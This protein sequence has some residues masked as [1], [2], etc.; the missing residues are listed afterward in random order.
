MSKY[1]SD[2]TKRLV[3]YVPGEQ[4]KDKTYIKL[5]TNENP[6]PPSPNVLA[7]I[8][9]AVQADLRLYPDPACQELRQAAARRFGRSERQVFIGNGSDEILA[10]SFAAFFTPGA[11]VLFPD[12]T[13]S[14]YK[15]YANLYGLPYETIALDEEFHVRLDAFHPECA[16][17]VIPNPNAPTG[18]YVPVDSFR[19]LLEEHAEH[20]VILDEA[21]IDFGGESALKLIDD[22]PNLLVIQTLSKSRS[23]AGMRVGMAFGQEDL[24]EGLER[25]KNSFNSYTLD[26]MALAGA[27]AALEDEDYFQE[28]C[29]NVIR[30]REWTV[31]QLEELGCS[32]IESKA[33]F[34]MMTH[35]A[36][37]AKRLFEELR[38][39][40][41]LVRYFAQ[42]RIDN[43]LRV[44]IGTDEEMKQFV[45]TVSKIGGII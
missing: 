24:I 15:V 7:A 2:L 36:I 35:P 3:P 21:Y 12:I 43:Y 44:S 41:I 8:Q 6:Y 31:K 19:P 10:F 42:P 11:P 22:Y 23:L 29:R 4:P 38:E 5:N 37:P 28:T 45:D 14:F 30:T 9:Q 20:V 25:V 33:N 1:W 17:V 27:A 39:Q 34:V 26:R 18:K 40:G 13:Y 32:V 16:G